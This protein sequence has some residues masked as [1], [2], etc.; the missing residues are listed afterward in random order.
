MNAKREHY[1]SWLDDLSTERCEV[2]LLFPRSIYADYSPPSIEEMERIREMVA[3]A[4][5]VTRGTLV[6]PLKRRM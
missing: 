3:R 5:R 1:S 4:A 2:L 6:K